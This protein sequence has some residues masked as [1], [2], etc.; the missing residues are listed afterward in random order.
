MMETPVAEVKAAYMTLGLDWTAANA[1]IQIDDTTDEAPEEAAKATE[2]ENG[3]DD[4]DTAQANE[5]KIELE[6]LALLKLEV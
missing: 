4:A 3:G 1:A 6:R 2:P 5:I